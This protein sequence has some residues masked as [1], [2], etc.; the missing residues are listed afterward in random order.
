MWEQYLH[1]FRNT[2]LLLQL[3]TTDGAITR[4]V[5]QAA[6]RKLEMYNVANAAHY[7][8]QRPPSNDQSSVPYIE[9]ICNQRDNVSCLWRHQR[10]DI[11]ICRRW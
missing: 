9:N 1:M 7:M 3:R 4:V 6:M 10:N 8:E 2:Q 11:S 5:A